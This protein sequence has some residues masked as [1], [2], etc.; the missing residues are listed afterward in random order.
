[1]ENTNTIEVYPE[2]NGGVIDEL[3][4]TEGMIFRDE[5]SKK[6]F[7]D[8]KEFLMET[9]LAKW[10]TFDEESFRESLNDYVEWGD[11]TSSFECQIFESKYKDIYERLVRVTTLYAKYLY[12]SSEVDK[13]IVLKKPQLSCF[14]KGMFSRACN[15]Q[16]VRTGAFF[17]FT[18]LNQDFALRDVFIGFLNFIK[19]NNFNILK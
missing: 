15:M 4:V 5:I 3:R 11:E 1:M 10:R 14:L 17:N 7:L 19:Y 8:S 16:Q 18:P 13:K 9:L 2:L 12:A 6:L